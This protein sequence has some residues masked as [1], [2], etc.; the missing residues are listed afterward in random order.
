MICDFNKRWRA[1]FVKH[2]G[3]KSA[4]VSSMQSSSAPTSSNPR[5]T[6]RPANGCTTRRASPISNTLG[7]GCAL[8][9]SC[10]CSGKLSRCATCTIPPNRSSSARPTRWQNSSS[11]T[12]RWVATDSGDCDQ[13][14]EQYCSSLL[15]KNANGPS[16]RNRCQAVYSWL[17]SVS[18]TVVSA[19]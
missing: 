7:R 5:F 19:L 6:P 9:A 14:T 8:R 16:T 4:F 11:E 18:T 3:T 15:G 1:N 10:C 12:A 17:R 13:T 2:S